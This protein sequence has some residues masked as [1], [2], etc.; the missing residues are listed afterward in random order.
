M[1][2][3]FNDPFK[4]DSLNCSIGTVSPMSMTLSS[5]KTWCEPRGDTKWIKEWVSVHMYAQKHVIYVS[6]VLAQD[7]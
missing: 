7:L 4:N 3:L 1:T 2:D 6:I 5:F